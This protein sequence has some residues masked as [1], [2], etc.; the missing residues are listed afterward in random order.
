M[1]ERR[2]SLIPLARMGA[3]CSTTGSPS[4]LPFSMLLHLTDGLQV[5]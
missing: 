3:A 5:V 1:T 2:Q 4:D